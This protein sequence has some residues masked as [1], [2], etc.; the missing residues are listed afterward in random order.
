MDQRVERE[1]IVVTAKNRGL[2]AISNIE[3]YAL[4]IYENS[5]NDPSRQDEL[6]LSIQVQVNLLNYF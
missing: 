4:E 1:H 5:L 6:F 2:N 3:N